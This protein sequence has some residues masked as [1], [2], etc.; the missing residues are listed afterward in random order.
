MRIFVGFCLCLLVFVYFGRIQEIFLFLVPLQL[1]KA[2]VVLGLIGILAAAPRN[3]LSFVKETPLGRMM[4]L[5]LVL[6]IIGIPFSVWPG[7]SVDSCKSLSRQLLMVSIIVGLARFCGTQLLRFSCMLAV[8]IM[9]L[10]MVLEESTGRTSAG[11]RYDP[12]DIALLFIVFLPVV[13]AEALHGGRFWRPFAWSI[14][15]MA[16]MGIALTGSRGGILALAAVGIHVLFAMKTRRWL[17]IPLLAIGFGLT[18]GMVDDSVWER[19]AA[20]GDDSDYNF[21]DKNGRIVIWGHGIDFFIRNPLFGVGIG[22]FGTAIFTH[23]F[24]AGLTAHNS[25][26]Q[27]G[28][29]LGLPGLVVFIAI[30]RILYRLS[31]KGADADFLSKADRQRFWV[32]RFSLA[33]FCVGGFFLS[34]AYGVI[35]YTFVALAA[36]MFLELRDAERQALAMEQEVVFVED[37]S[38]EAVSAESSDAPESPPPVRTLTRTQREAL[39]SH[40]DA[41][42]LRRKSQVS[43]ERKGGEIL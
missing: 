1:G 32:L 38:A 5:L 6:A 41:H 15:V 12:N 43:Q 42:A 28:T 37:I 9:A 18:L 33:G 8:G 10:L 25:F 2:G 13:I 3:L 24:G 27:I 16:I 23:G 19:F 21:S 34:Q 11:T 35:L 7:G 29:E 20:L 36:A 31:K 26:I 4:A 40:G 14:A 22:Q 39:L 30:L 17:L